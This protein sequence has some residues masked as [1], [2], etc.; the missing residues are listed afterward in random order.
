MPKHADEKHDDKHS[1]SN[2]DKL[3]LNPLVCKVVTDPDNPPE[4]VVLVGYLGSAGKD[5]PDYCRVYTDL[6]FRTYYELLIADV[7]YAEEADPA[8]LEKPTK[9]FVDASA[10]L[11]LVQALDA[12]F[13]QGMIT[14]TYPIGLPGV[15]GDPAP[16]GLGSGCVP[17]GENPNTAGCSPAH[18]NTF[19]CPGGQGSVSHGFAAPAP[20]GD[21]RKARSGCPGGLAA[22][23]HH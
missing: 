10:K 19:G 17:G 5:K 7:P 3:P 11:T 16:G 6:Y 20:G 12:S 13:I 8:D 21:P 4:I 22:S 2:G 9:I 23:T 1:K 14:S 18:P 15:L